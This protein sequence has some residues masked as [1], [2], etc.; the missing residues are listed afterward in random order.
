MDISQYS[1]YNNPKLWLQSLFVTGIFYL[2]STCD[3]INQTG[4]MLQ[5]TSPVSFSD[6]SWQ[7][8][9]KLKL[10]RSSKSHKITAEC[11]CTVL[12]KRR[13]P[14]AMKKII[15]KDEE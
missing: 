1:Y 14:I 3:P 13:D 2:T 11:V 8:L 4:T 12:D 6:I 10:L 7:L 15:K 9:Q 5:C